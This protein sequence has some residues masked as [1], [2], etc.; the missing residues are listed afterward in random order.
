ML[1]GNRPTYMCIDLNLQMMKLRQRGPLRSRE[2]HVCFFLV[3]RVRA[4]E[5][6]GVC[7]PLDAAALFR[8][9]LLLYCRD[10]ECLMPMPTLIVPLLIIAP[11]QSQ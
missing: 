7:V 9:P 1:L 2:S 3:V 8:C 5:G 11:F 10:L 4:R 6:V